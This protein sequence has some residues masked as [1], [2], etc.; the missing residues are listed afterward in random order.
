MLDYTR[1]ES[2]RLSCQVKWS[3]E[4]D[5]AAVTI[6][7]RV[8]THRNLYALEYR[9]HIGHT[10]LYLPST[11]VQDGSAT[12]PSQHWQQAFHPSGEPSKVGRFQ[13]EGAGSVHS[14][15]PAPPGQRPSPG[16]M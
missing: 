15:R 5:G 14:P 7:P 9:T 13:G 1:H 2:S 11:P 3:V 12:H 6:A 10:V 16:T 8:V 4:L